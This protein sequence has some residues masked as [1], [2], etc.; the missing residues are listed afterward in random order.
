MGPRTELRNEANLAERT[1][2]GDGMSYPISLPA[3]G[4][5][6]LAGA[7]RNRSFRPLGEEYTPRWPPYRRCST[8]ESGVGCP[9]RGAG[10]RGGVKAKRLPA[11]EQRPFFRRLAGGLGGGWALGA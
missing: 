10:R 9:A 4:F 1:A 3:F 11:S 2:Y 5:R 7:G 6:G 8:Y